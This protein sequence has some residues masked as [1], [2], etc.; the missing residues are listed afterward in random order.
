MY[1][2]AALLVNHTFLL[3][4][5][6]DKILMSLM[7]T[8]FILDHQDIYRNKLCT[9]YKT[10]DAVHERGIEYEVN[11][12]SLFLIYSAVL[13]SGHNATLPCLGCSQTVWGCCTHPTLPEEPH[14]L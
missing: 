4:Y 11:I 1:N 6:E 5:K 9:G 8:F 2:N 7:Y 12:I 3:S 10:R 14:D 13:K